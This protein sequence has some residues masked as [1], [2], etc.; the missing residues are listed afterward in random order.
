M[1]IAIKYRLYP[2]QEQE[3]KLEQTLDG[4]RWVYNYFRSKPMSV[5]DMQLVLTELKESHPW[6]RKYHSKMLQMVVHQIDAARTALASLKANRKKTGV[7]QYSAGCNTFVYNQSGF[8]IEKHGN[9]NLLWLSKVGYCEIRLHR[10]PLYIKQ[11]SVT[12]K[13]SGKWFANIVCD[14]ASVVMAPP[15]DTSKAVGIDVGITKF[16]H[17]S[18]NHEI[19]NPLHYDKA[20]KRMRRTDRRLSCKQLGSNNYEKY[21]HMRAKLW[22]RLYNKRHDFLHKLSTIYAKEYDLVFMEKLNVSNMVRNHFLARTILD[23]GWSRFKSMLEYKAKLVI[24]VPARD[25]SVDCSR[26]GNKVPKSLAVWTHRCG[27]CGLVIDRDYNASLNILQHGLA[28]LWLQQLPRDPGEVTPPEIPALGS[29][30]EEETTVIKR[31]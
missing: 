12:R 14:D 2:T 21:K 29:R 23:S 15:I 31:W 16:C 9:T 18:D 30:K 1:V 4:C 24:A 13:P 5:N 7:L 6:L 11:I 28:L 22:E 20:L 26:C 27:G 25:T 17:D 19:D 10:R 3:E 8:K